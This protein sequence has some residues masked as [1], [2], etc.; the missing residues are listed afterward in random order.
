M[1]IAG[2]TGLALALLTATAFAA[3]TW[4]TFTDP[5]GTFRLEVPQEPVV[6]SRTRPAPNGGQAKG[7]AYMVSRG[8]SGMLVKVD[9]YVGPPADPAVLLQRG[10]DGLQLHGRKLVSDAPITVDGHVGRDVA[11]VT[12]TGAT[13]TDRLFVI[14]NR[15]YQVLTTVAAGAQ[16]DQIDMVTRYSGSLHFLK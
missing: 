2:I 3:D 14:D 10:I 6:I 16:K 9:D 8:S 15:I 7:E 13:M 1:R 11:L 12:A 4:S 5:S